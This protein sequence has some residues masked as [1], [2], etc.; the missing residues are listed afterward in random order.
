MNLLVF[1]PGIT[2][3]YAWFCAGQR[4]ESG[5]IGENVLEEGLKS[6]RAKISNG[7][8]VVAERTVAPPNSTLG[9]DLE[10][11]ERLIAG[12]FPNINWIKA[13]D[14]KASPA[15]RFQIHKG[16]GPHER[17]AIRI[18]VWWMKYR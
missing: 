14:W 4:Q 13:A 10:Q 7:L 17:D 11:I 16:A 1:D 8:V 3:G 9:R 18:G 6:L 15:K 5:A 2:T 12:T